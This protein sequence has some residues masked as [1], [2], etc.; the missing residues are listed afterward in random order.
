VNLHRRPD[1]PKCPLVVHFS[2]TPTFFF[3][4]FFIPSKP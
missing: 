1:D 4:E 3:E 2:E